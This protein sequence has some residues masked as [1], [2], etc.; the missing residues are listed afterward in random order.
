MY[1]GI[2]LL[3]PPLARSL[4]QYRSDRLGAAFDKAATFDPPYKGAMFPWESAQTGVETIPTG[5]DEGKLEVHISSDIVLA[6][7]QYYRL[8]HDTH[9]LRSVGWPI[10]A[11]VADFWVSRVTI[12]AS[13]GSAHIRDVQ[14]RADFNRQRRDSFTH[15]SCNSIFSLPDV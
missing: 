4:L 13:D 6:V 8:T 10:V 1:P 7:Q 9:W 15:I 2:A 14:V 12:D 11:G 3:H 5:N